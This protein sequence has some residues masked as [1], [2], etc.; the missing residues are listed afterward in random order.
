MTTELPTFD[1]ELRQQMV[2][3]HARQAS[4]NLKAR[5]AVALEK[6]AIDK[7]EELAAAGD[8]TQARIIMNRYTP[9][10]EDAAGV[11][12]EQ[13]TKQLLLASAAATFRQED[14]NEGW[15]QMMWSGLISMLQP[16]AFSYLGNVD[17]G[18]GGFKQ[19]GALAR[20]FTPGKDLQN[21]AEAIWTMSSEELAKNLPKIMANIRSNST[22]L[23]VT[24]PTVQ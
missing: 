24:T 18:V 1:K 22:Y 11:W 23:G 3:H 9:G 15:G 10:K 13:N 16:S 17:E 6:D 7:M 12:K 20:F 5:M 8:Y 19:R 14:D 4:E 2:E 21:Q